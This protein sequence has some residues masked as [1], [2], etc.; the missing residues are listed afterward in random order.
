M[1]ILSAALTGATSGLGELAAI[2]LA[3][4]GFALVLLARSAARADA[5]IARIH[6]TA[7]GADVDVV[8]ADLTDLEQVREAGADIARRHSRIDVLINNAG[9]HAF[10]PRTTPAGLPEMMV[11]NY[12]APWVLTEALRSTLIASAPARVVTV[13]SEASRRHG[14]LTLPGDLTDTSPFTARGSSLIYGR[15]KLLDIMFTHELARRL[16]GT[17]VTANALDPGFNVTGLGRELRFSGVLEKILRAA[18]VGDPRRGT[19]GIV[20]L[21]TDAGLTDQ[22]GGYYSAKTRKQL[23]PTAPAGDRD[24]ER[25]LWE[26]TEQIVGAAHVA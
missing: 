24:A 5:T 23:T 19:A 26:F 3:R 16:A 20:R 15:T 7:P 9:L 13:A 8:L 12:F 18:H 14:T 11:V 4:R 6:E 2:D 21:A 10:T 1:T 25:R 22:T 17:G